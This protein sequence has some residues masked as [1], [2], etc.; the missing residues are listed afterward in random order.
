MESA[1]L[2]A[3][4]T[5]RESSEARI[6]D[7]AMARYAK[8]D[9]G[10]WPSLH[11]ELGLMF[12][13]C[14]GRMSLHR[15][16]VDDLVQESF[17]RVHRA[18]GTFEVGATLKPWALAIAR[19]VYLD[20]RRRETLRVDVCSLD[21]WD[22]DAGERRIVAIAREPDAERWALSRETI[23]I[24]R[25]ALAGLP[26]RTRD[27]FVLTRIERWTDSEAAQLLGM[28]RGA[29]RT[30][31]FRAAEALRAALTRSDRKQ[32]FDIARIPC[33]V[34]VGTASRRADPHERTRSQATTHAARSR[35]TRAIEAAQQQS[36]RSASTAPHAF[37]RNNLT[38]GQ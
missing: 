9:L 1:D 37:Q 7:D 13:R 28:T 36:S 30:R 4:G 10:A 35:R 15:S 21:D 33:G 17:L 12:R 31:A 2:N 22:D 16:A 24:V 32:Y 6:I 8:G 14:L 5:A 38:F 25:V 11:R 18:R 27:A 3:S 29:V 23:E 19:N 26:R 34:S 20:H